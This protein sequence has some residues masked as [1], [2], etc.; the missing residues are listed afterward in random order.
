MQLEN[1][2]DVIESIVVRT[3]GK[4]ASDKL[5]EGVLKMEDFVRF[6]RFQYYTGEFLLL[7]APNP[8]YS[9]SK[10]LKNR[11]HSNYTNAS[12]EME[13]DEIQKFSYSWLAE[14]ETKSINRSVT[15]H[16]ETMVSQKFTPTIPLI[17][18]ESKKNVVSP[19]RPLNELKQYYASSNDIKENGL[20]I[21]KTYFYQAITF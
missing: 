2:V 12:N 16:V 1:P 8:S 13:T 3:I 15:R 7:D 19:W 14:K 4:D 6:I 5:F 17:L 11:F 20:P 10:D 18:S 21:S 9:H